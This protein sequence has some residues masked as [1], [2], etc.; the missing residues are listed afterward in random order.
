MIYMS[1]LEWVRLG[2]LF[3]PPIGAITYIMSHLLALIALYMTEVPLVLVMMLT[4][5]IAVGIGLSIVS[6][7]ISI[8][9]MVMVVVA[10]FTMM[11]VSIPV[12]DMT[13]IAF[14]EMVPLV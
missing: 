8:A 2:S 11:M 14:R 5:T 12:E 13:T 6:L 7:P 1:F 9:V 10:I 3:G 4:I